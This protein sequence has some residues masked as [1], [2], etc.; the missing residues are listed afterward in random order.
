[1]SNFVLTKQYSWEVLVF[2]FNWK[3][4]A[5]EA[6]RMLV[7]VYGD[8]APTDNSNSNARRACRYNGSDLTSSFRTI[9]IHGNDSKVRQLGSVRVEVEKR[10]FCSMS[11]MEN[12]HK[13]TEN[14]HLFVG[15]TLIEYG[16][17]PRDSAP[18]CSVKKVNFSDTFACLQVVMVTF[19]INDFCLLFFNYIKG[20]PIGT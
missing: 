13:E 9:K 11:T 4:S 20:L 16:N 17:F 2:C 1:M 8:N 10:R 15:S 7:E 5:T 18:A 6:H 3:K 19:Y 14:E 12:R